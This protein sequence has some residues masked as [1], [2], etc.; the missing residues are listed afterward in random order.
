MS[1]KVG[2]GSILVCGGGYARKL[3]PSSPTKEDDL[4]Y[5]YL[6]G[7][8]KGVFKYLGRCAVYYFPG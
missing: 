4:E 1:A 2:G 5:F 8:E 6:Q 3:A 7:R